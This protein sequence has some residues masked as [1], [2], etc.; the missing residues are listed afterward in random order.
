M[1]SPTSTSA[2]PVSSAPVISAT[3]L[4]TT[5]TS[6][7]PDRHCVSKTR[8]TTTGARG[9]ERSP[10][11]ATP[12][13]SKRGV[14]QASADACCTDR[15]R[16]TSTTECAPTAGLS[17]TRKPYE[18]GRWWVEPLFAE[19]KDW[20]GM[21]RFR[22]RR[23]EKANIEALLIASGQN[24]KR[25]LAFGGRRPK[26]PAQAAALRPPAAVHEICHVREHRSSHPWRPRRAFFN[27][28]GRL[29]NNGLTQ[30]IR[31]AVE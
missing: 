12:A 15:S 29:P 25:L 26:K 11:C 28:V 13:S 18:R 16:R 21:R 23:L 19:A 8:T 3:I 31:R 30:V 7:R 24:V 20:H 17:L 1:R 14:P 4:R 22:L 2:T 6:A 9:T 10:R 27:S 5:T